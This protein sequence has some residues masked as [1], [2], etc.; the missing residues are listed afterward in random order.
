MNS[1]KGILG[2]I[3][4]TFVVV[5]VILLILVIF[6]FARGIIKK[7]AGVEDGVKVVSEAEVGIDE[8]FNYLS[9][10]SRLAEVKVLVRQGKAYEDA[11]V[12]AGYGG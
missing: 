11:R 7:A 6:V 5:V 2:G 4:A 1:K 8:V 3:I 9:D 10:Y 12:E